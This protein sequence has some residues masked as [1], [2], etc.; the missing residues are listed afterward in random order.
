[1]SLDA[2]VTIDFTL[3]NVCEEGDAESMGMTFEEMVRWLIA[4]EG[5]FGVCEDEYEI[6]KVVR[7]REGRGT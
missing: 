2:K 3:K 5:L 6:R 4:E 7:T 1:M